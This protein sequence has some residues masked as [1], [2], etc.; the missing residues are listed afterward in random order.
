MNE[1]REYHTETRDFLTQDFDGTESPIVE[2]GYD[3]DPRR[4]RRCRRSLDFVDF[5]TLY[6]TGARRNYQ[7]KHNRRKLEE[8]RELRGE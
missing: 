7:Q 6:A 1:Y 3:G 2:A 4:A 8:R 5:L